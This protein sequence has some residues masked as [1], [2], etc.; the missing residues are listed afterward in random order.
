MF[1]AVPSV[2]LCVVVINQNI[3]TKEHSMTSNSSAQPLPSPDG[4]AQT[5]PALTIVPPPASKRRSP[6]EL[7]RVQAGELN[8][9][10][11]ICY[12]AQKSAYTTTLAE[13]EITAEFV[14]TL[15]VDVAAART[16]SITAVQATDTKEGATNL[17]DL[18]AAKLIRGI[19]IIQTAARQKYLYGDP[20]KLGNYY[21]GQRIDESRAVLD[22]SSQA[23]LE[24]ANLDTLPGI[25]TAFLTALA[26][27]R[28]EW[29]ACT[30]SQSTEISRAKTE[31]AQRNAMVDSIQERRTKLQ[32]AADASWPWSNP[33][34]AGVRG[35]FKLPQD[36]PLTF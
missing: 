15:L 13:H 36:R 25:T 2:D 24:K 19:R 31:R 26:A 17:Q 9:A 6:M 33:E 27:D 22:Q 32:F 12:A 3:Q 8:K 1:R 10:E 28:T 35:E 30:A 23:I 18:C 7:N 29:K 16:R 20:T 11:S 34:N 4:G 21:V 14:A 5:P